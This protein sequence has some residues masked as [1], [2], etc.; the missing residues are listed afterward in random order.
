MVKNIQIL[1]A[2]IIVSAFGFSTYAQ[3]INEPQKIN[4]EW[5]QPYQ[6]FRI[7]GNVYY[8]GT[9]DLAC[10]LIVTAD[11]N[12]LINTGLAASASMIIK[13]IEVLGFKVSDIKILM[14]TQAHYD[15][16]GAMADLQKL[17][18][19]KMLVNEKDA[20]ALTD[21][22]ISDYELGK[23]GVTFKPMRVDGKLQNGDTI[24][25][26]DARIVMLHH[27]GHTKGS[28]S[29]LF[30]VKEDHRIYTV[31]IANMPSI[32]TDE[33]FSNIS[34]YPDIE[35]DYAYTLA[36]LKKL[37]FDLWLSSHASQFGLHTK[38]KPGDAYNP[39]AFSDK[40]GYEKS[41]SELEE[42]YVK[43]LEQK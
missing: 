17:T 23:Y 39:H 10:Y 35:K 37:S 4:P 2:I 13:N 42:Q 30:D 25:L 21:G 1:L 43:K 16:L 12:I 29:F 5:S 3:K 26:G 36:S 7:V 27:P 34:S 14:T 31:L 6:P 24:K 38:R 40:E 19:A 41:I 22:G 11:G 20:K 18:G 33:K 9:Y 15:H 8:V 32:I 28:S